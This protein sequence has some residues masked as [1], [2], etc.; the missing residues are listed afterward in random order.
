ML[1]QQRGGM[2][3][4]QYERAGQGWSSLFDRIDERVAAA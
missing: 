3:P 4:E 1:F 2:S